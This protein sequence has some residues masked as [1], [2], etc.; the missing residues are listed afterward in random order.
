MFVLVRT[1]NPGAADLFDA[2]LA[3]GGPLWERLAALVADAGAPGPAS[4]L[5]DV[6]AVCGATAPRTSR[7]CAS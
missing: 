7:G 6:G 4:G 3:D 2:E 1:S 5:S